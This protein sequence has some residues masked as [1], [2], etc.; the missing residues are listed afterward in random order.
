MPALLLTTPDP[1][2]DKCRRRFSFL[3]ISFHCILFCFFGLYPALYFSRC[4][5]EPSAI[6]ATQ[7]YAVSKSG[8]LIRN[9]TAIHP[10]QNKLPCSRV[11]WLV[12]VS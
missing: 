11:R 7:Y 9:K 4:L 3:F 10:V 5:D 2:H 1:S 6:I 12:A 8:S